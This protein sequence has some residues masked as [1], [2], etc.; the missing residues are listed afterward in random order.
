APPAVASV[1]RYSY[2]IDSS[3]HP[4]RLCQVHSDNPP[5]SVSTGVDSTG[6]LKATPN[7]SLEPYWERVCPPDDD[8]GDGHRF[9]ESEPGSRVDGRPGAGRPGEHLPSLPRAVAR[10]ARRRLRQHPLIAQCGAR[11]GRG[12]D[13]HLLGWQPSCSWP[14]GP[15]PNVTSPWPSGL[16]VLTRPRPSWGPAG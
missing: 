13:R 7:R 2:T 16:A 3:R 5:P 1:F 14:T 9:F 8:A 15:R 12:H 6:R 10:T 4:L 11:E